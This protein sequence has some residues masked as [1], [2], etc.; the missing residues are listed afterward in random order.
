MTA[1]MK[2][3]QE[4][5]EK[6]FD[7]VAK[8]RPGQGALY[9]KGEEYFFSEEGKSDGE[10]IDYEFYYTVRR[11]LDDHSQDRDYALSMVVEELRKRDPDTD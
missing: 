3:T 8:N 5:L 7:E 2:G 4:S 10:L 1:K 6:A 9:R 11:A